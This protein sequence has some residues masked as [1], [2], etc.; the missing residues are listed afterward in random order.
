MGYNE[1]IDQI[2][3]LL[4]KCQLRQRCE[5]VDTQYIE[6][7]KQKYES[8]CAGTSTSEISNEPLILI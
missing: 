7:R 6:K 2:Y 3:Y 8:E 5:S 1:T 4:S